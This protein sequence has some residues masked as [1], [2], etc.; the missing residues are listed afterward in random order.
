MDLY[1]F[2]FPFVVQFICSI[3]ASLSNQMSFPEQVFLSRSI[4]VPLSWG[5][6]VDEILVP[7]MINLGASHRTK[8]AI[9]SSHSKQ[10]YVFKC[11]WMMYKRAPTKPFIKLDKWI[12]RMLYFANVFRVLRDLKSHCRF[13]E[14]IKMPPIILSAELKCGLVSRNN[15]HLPLLFSLMRAIFVRPLFLI[16]INLQFKTSKILKSGVVKRN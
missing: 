12:R 2:L 15:S 14:A 5:I 6:K 8:N 9:F 7:L 10:R 11:H 1:L 16:V 13:L 4:P 3:A